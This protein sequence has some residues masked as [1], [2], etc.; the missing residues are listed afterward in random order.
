[1]GF[2][3]ALAGP[4]FKKSEQRAK[5]TAIGTFVPFI[6]YFLWDQMFGR[7][8]TVVY[9]HKITHVNVKSGFTPVE[10]KSDVTFK[11]VTHLTTKINS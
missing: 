6:Y 1:M 5:K 11:N 8:L 4:S 7:F 9:T 3:V 2:H 10:W